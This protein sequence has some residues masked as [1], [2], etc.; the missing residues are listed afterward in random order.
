MKARHLSSSRES[1][2]PTVDTAADVLPRA[3]KVLNKAVGH[4]T[5]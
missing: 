1:V 2:L 3:W 4:F 5:D